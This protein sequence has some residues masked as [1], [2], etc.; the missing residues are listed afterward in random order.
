M[1]FLGYGWKPL[2]IFTLKFA[3]KLLLKVEIFVVFKFL[4]IP[5]SYVVVA[6]VLCCRPQFSLARACDM[7]SFYS[8]LSIVEVQMSSN[9][10]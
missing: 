6:M 10:W 5:P 1:M 8:A 9:L 2:K 4:K 3:A 7:R